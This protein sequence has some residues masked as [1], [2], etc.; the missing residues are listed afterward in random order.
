[1]ETGAK[2]K[3]SYSFLAPHLCSF[4]IQT[5]PAF[6]QSVLFFASVIAAKAGAVKAVATAKVTNAKRSLF[7]VMSPFVMLADQ[8]HMQNEQPPI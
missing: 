7:M 4:S 8:R 3:V 5:P 6:S 2:G 1:M